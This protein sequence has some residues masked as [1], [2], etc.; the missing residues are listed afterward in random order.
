MAENTPCIQAMCLNYPQKNS[1]EHI[2]DIFSLNRLLLMFEI[3]C[4][5]K[6]SFAPN[7]ASNMIYFETIEDPGEVR[8]QFKKCD[9]P[10]NTY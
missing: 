3:P 1:Y 10:A 5:K 7:H 6:E 9:L 2:E 8:F 4:H